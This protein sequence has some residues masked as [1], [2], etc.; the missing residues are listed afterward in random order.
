MGSGSD[1]NRRSE[2][3][4]AASNT[5]NFAGVTLKPMSSG[6][7]RL[8]L[9]RWPRYVIVLCAALLIWAR[10]GPMDPL[11]DAP[12]STALIDRDGELLGATVA[13]DGQWRLPPSDSI[14]RRFAA[15][16]IQFEDRRFEQH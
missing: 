8:L 13:A 14:P 2:G 9:S 1:E 6:M 16:L 5:S 15:C 12:L 7:H 11:F 3:M 10:W 4:G